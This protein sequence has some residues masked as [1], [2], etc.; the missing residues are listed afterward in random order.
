[1][2]RRARAIARL[3]CRSLT[4]QLA[5]RCLIILKIL[6]RKLFSFFETLSFE[7]WRICWNKK[8]NRF[9]SMFSEIA[10]QMSSIV[11]LF[12]HR[13][14]S[15]PNFTSDIT[16][17]IMVKLQKNWQHVFS[18]F[19]TDHMNWYISAFITNSILNPQLRT[20]HF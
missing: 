15:C 6:I 8:I 17:S 14:F 19:L 18:Y 3:I 4:L 11:I 20:T 12:F 7:N 10:E 1:M 16:S 5:K 13:R 2:Q 9:L